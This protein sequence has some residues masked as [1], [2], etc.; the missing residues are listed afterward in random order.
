[1]PFL[2]LFFLNSDAENY[3]KD[4]IDKFY[5][6]IQLLGTYYNTAR[7]ASGQPIA[8]LATSLLTMINMELEKE[9][10]AV[11]NFKTDKFAHQILSQVRFAE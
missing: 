10:R 6:S 5:S 2:L 7:L 8:I 4:N 1:M 9:L 3:K 11:N